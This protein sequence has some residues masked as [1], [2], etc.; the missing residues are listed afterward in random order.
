MP[1]DTILK[2]PCDVQDV[3]DGYHTF[4]ELYAHRI[5]LF[6]ALMAAAHVPCWKARKNKDGSQYDGWFI[7]WIETSAGEISYHIPN[8]HWDQCCGIEKPTH[9]TYDGYTSKDVEQRLIAFTSNL[10]HDG[11]F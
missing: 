11:K 10:I 6:L 2:L 1:I 4:R 8:Q 7:A 9:D 3:S 5:G